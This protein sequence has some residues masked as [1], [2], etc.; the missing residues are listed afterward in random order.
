VQVFPPEFAFIDLGS[1]VQ[2]PFADFKAE[3]T[4]SGFGG[5]IAPTASHLLILP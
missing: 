3:H 4:T 2:T 1:G 5:A